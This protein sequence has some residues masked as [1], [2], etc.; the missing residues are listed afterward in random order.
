MDSKGTNIN[1]Y[2]NAARPP[3]MPETGSSQGDPSRHFVDFSSHHDSRPLFAQRTSFI[4]QQIGGGVGNATER[5]LWGNHLVAGL[6][7]KR[8]VI[9]VVQPSGSPLPAFTIFTATSSSQVPAFTIFTPK[10]ISRSIL[11]SFASLPLVKSHRSVN[12][13]AQV[14]ATANSDHQNSIKNSPGTS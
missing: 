14:P 4:G 3:A 8:F 6:T 12:K 10:K 7:A 2:K 5:L 1:A 11:P 13:S 9:I